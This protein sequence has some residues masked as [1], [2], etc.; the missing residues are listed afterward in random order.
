MPGSVPEMALPD[1]PRCGWVGSDPV[2]QAY[3]DEEWCV[4]LHDDRR[5]FEMLTLETFQAGLSW[6]T[7]LKKRDAFRRAFADWDVPRIAR[8]P[9]KRVESLLQDPGIVRNRM[10]IEAAITNAQAFL[11]LQREE[12][13]FDAWLWHW[14]EGT[15]LRP[16]PRPTDWRTVPAETALSRSISK[17]LKKRGFRFVGPVICYSF[18]QAAGLVDDHVQG[19]WKA[20]PESD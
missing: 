7:I 19:C 13:S 16:T 15:P 18:L 9:S 4:P 5:L 17:E 10:K 11:R 20:A 14:T 1:R 8:F 6:I 3:H 12:G 2:Y